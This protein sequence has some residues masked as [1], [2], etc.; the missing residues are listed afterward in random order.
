M[1]PFER[2]YSFHEANDQKTWTEGSQLCDRGS[3]EGLAETAGTEE[4]PWGAGTRITEAAV[5]I[6][7]GCHSRAPL[8]GWLQ[9]QKLIVPPFWRLEVG[10]GGIGRAVRAVRE[11]VPRCPSL[12][13][14]RLTDN[15]W[16]F[17]A[18]FRSTSQICLP[19]PMPC[20]LCVC[21]APCPNVPCQCLHLRFPAS[22]TVTRQTRCWWWRFVTAALANEYTEHNPRLCES[23][24]FYFLV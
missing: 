19:L 15:A 18:L 8:T 3:W 13:F 2:V 22:S 9:Q 16:C 10:N 20:S 11:G 21:V 24:S 4:V 12:G 14:R 5:L 17:L 7:W 1:I 23:V 6:L